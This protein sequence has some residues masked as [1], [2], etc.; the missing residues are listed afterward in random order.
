[1]T[2]HGRHR[3]RG[4]VSCVCVCVRLC[5]CPVLGQ[6]ITNERCSLRV[7]FAGFISHWGAPGVKSLDGVGF[8]EGGPQSSCF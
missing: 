7:L 5:V 1:M 2:R 3:H 8:V 4:G 6:C